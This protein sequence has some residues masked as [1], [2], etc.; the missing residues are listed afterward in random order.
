MSECSNSIYKAYVNFNIKYATSTIMDT[1]Y[2]ET[3]CFHLTDS[4]VNKSIVS[5]VI[6]KQEPDLVLIDE[7]EGFPMALKT[8]LLRVASDFL[9]Y[10]GLRMLFFIT[11]EGNKITPTDPEVD[12]VLDVIS[13]V[14]ENSNSLATVAKLGGVFNNFE[15]TF[16]QFAVLYE[17][18][19]DKMATNASKNVCKFYNLD[20]GY[21]GDYL[22][23]LASNYMKT[24]DDFLTTTI[25]WRR[26]TIVDKQ[27]V[28]SS[29]EENRAM[30]R[31]LLSFISCDQSGGFVGYFT[32]GS[33]NNTA[34]FWVSQ[35]KYILEF[36]TL[37]LLKKNIPYNA[38]SI[39]DQVTNN[40]LVLIR[41]KLIS[42][43]Q[44]YQKLGV[45]LNYYNVTIPTQTT[46]ARNSGDVENIEISYS[47]TNSIIAVNGNISTDI[48]SSIAESQTTTLGISL[49][50]KSLARRISKKDKFK[51]ESW[52]RL[53]PIKESIEEIEKETHETPI[54]NSVVLEK[55]NLG[56]GV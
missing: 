29:A 43:L 22:Q 14:K 4:T 35:I 11:P 15:N 16:D 50:S 49:K 28:I 24:G 48:A 21:L 6:T 55:V 39:T 30:R 23:F 7:P 54:D 8:D 40:C 37:S 18:T 9:G 2:L 46:T 19:D 17:Q 33:M 25:I 34:C 31:N 45:I 27:N 26:H 32:S 12:T 10:G 3:V 1:S 38:L 47:A 51:Y 56:E 44:K 52:G 20:H 36:T 5:K 13:Y 41:A 42:T 53:K